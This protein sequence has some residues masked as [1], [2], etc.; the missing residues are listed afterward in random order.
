M[1][2]FVEYNNISAIADEAKISVDSAGATSY[3]ITAGKK[4]V[5]F[6]NT[7]TSIVWYGGS[8]IDP[9]NLRGNKLFPNQS[10]TYKNVN[11]KF[12][13]YFK[14][15]SGETSTISSVNHD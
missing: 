8:T 1:I 10:L 12:V 9:E 6:Q 13:I 2:N 14:C 15:G 11:Q 7:G 3:T 4:G 5:N